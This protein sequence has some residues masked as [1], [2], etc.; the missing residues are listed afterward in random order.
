MAEEYDPQVALQRL[1]Q[2]HETAAAALEAFLA[3]APRTQRAL[4]RSCPGIETFLKNFVAGLE[5]GVLE[6]MMERKFDQPWRSTT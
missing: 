1:L 5:R 2:F 6:G 4:E 3:L